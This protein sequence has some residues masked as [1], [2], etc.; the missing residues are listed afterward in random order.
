MKKN[1]Y[2]QAYFERRNRLADF[3][4]NTI[5]SVCSLPRLVLE[6]FLR[7]NMGERYFTLYSAV[8]VLLMLTFLPYVHPMAREFSLWELITRKPLW[9]AF[10]AA[11]SFFAFQRYQEIRRKPSVFDFARFSASAGDI[12]PFFRDIMP[13]GKA[14][15]VRTIEIFLEPLLCGIAGLLL[16]QMDNTLGILVIFCSLIYSLSYAAAY[17][18]GDN[19]MMEQIDKIICNEDLAEVFVEGAT[20]RRGF[21]WYGSK[22]NS[23]DKRAEHF[24]DICYEVVDD[25][26]DDVR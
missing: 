12:R 21:R 20:S 25:T 8:V 9:Y 22:P 18:S 14:P 4:L 11:Y 1:L 3:F 13:F 19:F 2:Y 5:F 6:V 24:E 17:R 15:D 26:V 16:Y 23:R 7:P 10:V